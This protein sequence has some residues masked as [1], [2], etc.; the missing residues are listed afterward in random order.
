MLDTE[1]T[2]RFGIDHP[3]VQA[4]M[5]HEAGA[6]LA[7]AVSNAGAL[8][9]IGSIG[10]TADHLAEQIRACRAATARPFAVNVVT[11]P[12]APWAFE[13]LE[14]ALAEH[15]PVVTLSFG[16]PLPWLE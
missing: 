9:T 1:F 2:R 13:L 12:W 10:G 11:W 15:A 5:G 14:I 3:L 7:S 8:G 4:G 6:R 16:D